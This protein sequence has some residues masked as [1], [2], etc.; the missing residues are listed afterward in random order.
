IRQLE[1]DI[2]QTEELIAQLESEIADPAIASDYALINEKCSQLDEA[3]NAI[4]EKMDE[5]A[6]LADM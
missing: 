1:K 2:E 3:R 5:W 6:E 4:E